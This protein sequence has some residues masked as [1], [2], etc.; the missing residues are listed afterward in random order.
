MLP[1]TGWELA[2]FVIQ[3]FPKVRF[4][5]LLDLEGNVLSKWRKA[6]LERGA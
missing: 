4:Y 6:L 5:R 1:A 2:A 3:D